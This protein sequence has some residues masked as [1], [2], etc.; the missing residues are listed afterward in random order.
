MLESH[1]SPPSSSPLLPASS[2]GDPHPATSFECPEWSEF[3]LLLF[4]L[5]RNGMF[6]QT[7]PYMTAFHHLL[8]LVY[9][10]GHLPFC[11]VCNLPGHINFMLIVSLSMEHTK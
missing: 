8:L 5:H 6:I 2:S 9:Y 10:C 3:Q 7:H 4:S 11:L 1:L